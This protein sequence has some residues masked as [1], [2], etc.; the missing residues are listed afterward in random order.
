MSTQKLD[1]DHTRGDTLNIIFSLDKE[2]DINLESTTVTFSLKEYETDVAYVFQVGKTDVSEV[3][4]EENTYLMRI[5]PSLTENLT[6]SNYFYDLELRCGDPQDVYTLVK[7]QIY[8]DRDITRSAVIVPVFVYPDVS[9]DGRINQIDWSLILQIYARQSVGKVGATGVYA[10][11]S[12][13]SAPSWEP[14]TYYWREGTEEPYVYHLTI[15][16]PVYWATQYTDYFTQILSAEEQADRA[17]CDRDGM[18]TSKDASY[19]SGF[20][21][22]LATGKYNNDLAGWTAYM[23]DHYRP[24]E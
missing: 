7:G 22:A 1:F 21:S 20:I 18:I 11:V 24:G 6:K 9:G 12:G 16:E 10:A 2:I 5:D 14:D 4:D 13:A 8:L 15:E 23:T 3:E 19:V 17:D